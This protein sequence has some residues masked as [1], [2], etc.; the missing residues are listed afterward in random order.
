MLF[1]FAALSL[2]LSSMQVVLQAYGD[3]AWETFRNVGVAFS[4]G[5]YGSATCATRLAGAVRRE[6]GLEGAE[7]GENES[8]SGVGPLMYEVS[9][10]SSRPPLSPDRTERDALDVVDT[11]CGRR[12]GAP[13]PNPTASYPLRN[14]SSIRCLVFI[15]IICL[16]RVTSV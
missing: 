13:H 12:C 5:R 7:T 2:V 9:D 1:L 3:A 4:G 6:V 15:R 8:S 10:S 14:R 11:Y 16:I